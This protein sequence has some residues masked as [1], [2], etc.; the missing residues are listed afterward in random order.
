MNVKY[1]AVTTTM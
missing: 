1:K